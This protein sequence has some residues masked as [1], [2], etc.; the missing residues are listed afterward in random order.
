MSALLLD[1]AGFAYGARGARQSWL[2]GERPSPTDRAVSGV[3]LD[4]S[5]G[6]V[7]L[8]CGPSGCGKSTLV[9][10]VNGLAPEFHPGALTGRIEVAGVDVV[11]GGLRAA[12]ALTTTVFQNP[13]TQFF[14]AD[15]LSELAFRGENLGEDPAGLVERARAALGA[16]GVVDLEDRLLA[17]LSGGQLQRVACAQAIVADTPVVLLDEP[18]SNLSPAGI[19]ALAEAIGTLKDRGAAVVIAEHRLHFLRGIADEVLLMDRGRPVRRFDAD[20]FYS[21]DDDARR[22]LG[23]RSLVE[24][25]L[26]AAPNGPRLGPGEAADALG[27]PG[28]SVAGRPG[29]GGSREAG[30][31][32]VRIE[33]V[34]FSYG[35]TP[36]LDD[37]DI[38]L[39]SGTISAIVG[40]NGAGKTTL[41]RLLCGLA[42]PQRGRILLDGRPVRR[43]RLL[44]ESAL[45]MQDVTRQLFAESVRADVRLGVDPSA[46]SDEDVMRILESV[47]LA[48]V[49]DRHP[50]TLSGGQKQRAAIACSLARRARIHVFDE[51]TSGVDL[52]HLE[53][54]A[55]LLRRL[56]DDG[57]V[58]VVITHD[59]ELVEA[60]ADRVIRLD[61]VESAGLRP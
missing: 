22:G 46:L 57:A 45:V 24:V 59:A 43:R 25:P 10:M 5:A 37:L 53:S 61:A 2:G 49:A 50:S 28:G 41:A 30:E 35:R 60:C 58:V 39:P 34:G 23:L 26:A 51:P 31:S 3:D 8:V 29:G 12:G 33:G 16:L 7:L 6:R 18:T 42:S 47:D 38:D 27:D 17:D 32:G 55:R 40:P 4:L 11:A 44:G 48:D 52:A 9:R 1:G 19:G 21:L 15:V 20:D 54:I 36:V 14:T 56:A 13:R